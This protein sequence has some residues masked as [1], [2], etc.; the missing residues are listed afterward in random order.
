MA[1]VNIDLEVVALLEKLL[2]KAREGEVHG[3]AAG[4]ERW[5]RS[6]GSLHR[7]H[8]LRRANADHCGTDP[9]DKWF[10]AGGIEP[11]TCR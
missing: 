9:A 1:K 5:L 8:G 2:G 7:W 6:V 10:G 3:V 11:L 4:Y